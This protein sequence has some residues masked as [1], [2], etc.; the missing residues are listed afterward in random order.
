MR[1]KLFGPEKIMKL[2]VKQS[3]VKARRVGGDS[4]SEQKMC[5][6]CAKWD[7]VT[8]L[9]P[10][11]E[12]GKTNIDYFCD[13]CLPAVKNNLRKLPYSSL[14]TWGTKGQDRIL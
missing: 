4:M 12:K 14:F 10:L 8:R 1:Y 13:R 2:E 9:T 5:L 7:D 6:Y 3:K 11:F